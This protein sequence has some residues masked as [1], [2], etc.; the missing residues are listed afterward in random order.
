MS[1]STMPSTSA[2]IVLLREQAIDPGLDLGVYSLYPGYR[3]GHMHLPVEACLE[4]YACNETD[5]VRIDGPNALSPFVLAID[6]ERT[7]WRFLRLFTALN[8]HYYFQ[9]ESYTLEPTE[10]EGDAPPG[11]LSMPARVLAA[12]GWEPPRM[13]REGTRYLAIRDLVRARPT[14][15]AAPVILLRRSERVSAGADYELLE[16]TVK[17]EIQRDRVPVPVYE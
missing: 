1:N 12:A 7:A 9:K 14:D 16:D 13:I 6:D 2:D 5:S 4:L 8:T 11:A 10:T 15:T 17:A 3:R